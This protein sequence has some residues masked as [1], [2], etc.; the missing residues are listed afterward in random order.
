M[1]RH[2]S[3]IKG[4]GILIVMSIVGCAPSSQAKSSKGTIADLI[5]HYKKY[6]I[7]GKY[8]PMMAPVIGAIEGG[9]VAGKTFKFEIYRY[10]SIDK[11]ANMSK[12][13]AFHYPVQSNGYF[14]IIIHAG[15]KEKLIKIFDSF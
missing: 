3:I 11:A 6:N 8:E 2:S 9:L 13:G 12:T 7:E 5:N 10:D 1:I 15:D 4:I 14:I